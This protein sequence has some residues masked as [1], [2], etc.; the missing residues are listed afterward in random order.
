V[1]TSA[2][3]QRRALELRA[4]IERHNRLYYQLDA[5]EISDAEYDAL[6]RELQTLE[7]AHPKLIT[8]DSPTQRVGAPPLDAF[9][10]VRHEIPMLS[11][12]NAMTDEKLAAFDQDL[13]KTLGIDSVEYVAE[14]KLDGLAVNLLY[15]NGVLIRGATRGDGETGED[16]TGN[17]RTIK[18]IPHRLQGEGYP[19]RFEARGEVFM[20]YRGLEELNARTKER[21][22]EMFVNPR[23]TAA[24]SLRQ[25]DPGVTA[26][27]PLRF[28]CYGCGLFPQ[29][30]LP[31]RLY[32]LMLRLRGWGFPVSPEMD[33]VHGIEGCRTNFLRLQEK[34]AALP[35]VIDGVVYKANR[36]NWQERMKST[37]HHPKWAIARKFPAEERPTRVV[38]IDVQVGRTG[39]L[40]PVARLEPVFVGGVTVTN[41]T[42][43]NQDEIARKDVRVGDTVIVRRAGD[44]IPE[45]VRIMP[46]R[47]PPGTEPFQMPDTCPACGSG[48]TRIPGETLV[49]CSG[50]LF[51]PAQH[52][53]S[54]KHFASRRAMDIDG[55]GDKLVDQLLESGRIRTVADI[56]RLR[57]EDVAALE[58]MGEKS[59]E[60][61]IRAIDRSRATTLPRFLH[62]L[63]IREVGEVTARTLARHF[64]SLDALMA[65]DA[66]AL[67]AAPDI[68]PVVADQ[69][70]TFFQ[71]PHNREVIAELRELG[72]HWQEENPGLTTQPLAGLTFV[73]TGALDTLTREEATARLQALG[74]KVA[75]S[76][77]KKTSFVVAGSDAG[78]KLAKARELGVAVLD[79]AGLLERLD[80]G[81][82]GFW[83]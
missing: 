3:P 48:V 79:E 10:P 71:Q 53:E 1:S 51:C 58:R 35:Y 41:A 49:R 57:A 80:A 24:G 38:A 62:A 59:A 17:I 75:G 31:E 68:G 6:L 66:S 4:E 81:A 39:T 46:E 12:E 9:A 18:D 77:S 40:T 5:P 83:R 29:E 43:H 11:L 72:V 16:I 44:V 67:Q 27:R 65:A 8:P 73:L 13:R 28:Y 22:E 23:N 34:R 36:F 20:D 70:V 7:Q 52:K 21:G 25:I 2:E 26:S 30:Y 19:P 14:P 69:I 56:Y 55:L 33:V 76:V 47:R 37:A 74:A 64:H 61:L 50:G 82:S 63:G 45:V 42:L 32:D 60:N 15:E 54:V 78:S